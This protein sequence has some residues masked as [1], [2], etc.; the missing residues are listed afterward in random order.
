MYRTEKSFMRDPAT[1]NCRIYVGN[2]DETI[3]SDSLEEHF[4]KHGK[5]IGVIVQRGFGFIQ[6]E[7]ET[8]AQE[9]IKNEHGVTFQGRKLNVKQAFDNKSKQND[10]QATGA[11]SKGSSAS[12]DGPPP[13]KM[14]RRGGH[15]GRGRGGGNMSN[16][17]RDSHGDD[18]DYKYDHCIR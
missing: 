4:K 14:P 17:D 16:M 6:F 7:E 13:R 12:Q 8:S 1:A 11:G 2:L 15:G 18:V 10:E 5:V 3:T 9:A